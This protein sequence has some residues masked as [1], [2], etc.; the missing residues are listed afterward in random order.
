MKNKFLLLI[1]PV[2]LVFAFSGLMPLKVNANTFGLY[3]NND[4]VWD[5]S[6]I[7]FQYQF[8]DLEGN[9]LGATCST[10]SYTSVIV[11]LY[12]QP[13]GTH[14]CNEEDGTY[15]GV[16]GT[17]NQPF[18]IYIIDSTEWFYINNTSSW[19]SINVLTE[20]SDP[21]AGAPAVISFFDSASTTIA[22]LPAGF[23]G[24]IST[25]I[26]GI[27]PLA[28]LFMATAF[29]FWILVEIQNFLIKPEKQETKKEY[30]RGHRTADK[31]T[32]KIN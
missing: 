32:A 26:G 3:K 9:I 24:V 1:L 13:Y 25:T 20:I 7:P 8:I 23:A 4:A 27:W 18:Y 17:T 21:F 30:K 15:F 16:N 14:T 29:A 28:L 10:A 6:D 31:Y 2:F 12:N 19:S 22:S 11:G 5:T